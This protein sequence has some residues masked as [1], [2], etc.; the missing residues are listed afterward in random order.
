MYPYCAE[1]GIT[2]VE[3]FIGVLLGRPYRSGDEG[4]HVVRDVFAVRAS[5][6][7]LPSID[8]G[9]LVPYSSIQDQG[10]ARRTLGEI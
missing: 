7:A 6:R 8:V 2:L 5:A 3:G 10:E 1:A 9:D 4:P